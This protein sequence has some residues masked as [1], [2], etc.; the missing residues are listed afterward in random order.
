MSTSETPQSAV[1]AWLKGLGLSRGN[2]FATVEA[3]QEREFLPDFFVDVEGYE[4]IKGN[5]TVIV[6]APRGAG[7][8]AL[9]VELASEAAPI[10]R[11]SST[12]V[13][14]YTDFD[15]LIAEYRPGQSPTITRHVERLLRAG[16]RALFDALC[17]VEKAGRR[18]EKY[19]ERSEFVTHRVAQL[20]ASV[21]LHLAHFLRQNF[22]TLIAPEA[23]L[24]QFEQRYANF[25]VDLGGFWQAIQER[26]LGRYAEQQ[27]WQPDPVMQ[28]LADLNDVPDER[29][30]SQASPTERIGRFVDLVKAVGFDAAHFLVGP[31]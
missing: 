4:L 5:Q 24:A 6:F 31:G 27:G 11:T 18:Q 26:R 20:P 16:A 3:D 1:E 8:S 23:L 15:E 29:I 17:G 22:P 14:E 21:R 10:L 25:A 12:L 19:L 28:L 30:D 7:K 2:P 9:R 13:V